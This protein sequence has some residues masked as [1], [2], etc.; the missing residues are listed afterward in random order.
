MDHGDQLFTLWSLWSLICISIR[1][2]HSCLV[3]CSFET[4]VSFLA[5]GNFYTPGFSRCPNACH[6]CPQIRGTRTSTSFASGKQSREA[7]T[8]INTAKGPPTW[9][10]QPPRM[11]T[12]MMLKAKIRLAT[13][14]ALTKTKHPMV[15]P[16][17]TFPGKDKTMPSDLSRPANDK[18]ADRQEMATDIA[19]PW[20]CSS[21]SASFAIASTSAKRDT[22]KF[23]WTK[24]EIVDSATSR[25]TAV[26]KTAMPPMFL[27]ELLLIEKKTD[28]APTLSMFFSKYVP[29]KLKFVWGPHQLDC[30]T[31]VNSISC[32]PLHPWLLAVEGAS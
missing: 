14:M 4:K 20:S 23:V 21:V 18:P 19:M 32:Q 13:S 28:P 22:K 2:I 11:E 3:H 25:E 10:H 12:W 17:P 30:H 7:S 27:Q 29:L 8:K 31:W 9:P 15:G 26:F 6:F 1:H 24:A 5:R 16:H